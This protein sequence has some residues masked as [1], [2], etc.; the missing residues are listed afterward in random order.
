M[1]GIEN[2]CTQKIVAHWAKAISGQIRA[3][4][5][6]LKTFLTKNENVKCNYDTKKKY[7]ISLLQKTVNNSG[8]FLFCI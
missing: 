4:L 5:K 7:S 3:G 6:F 1:T 8:I 2:H